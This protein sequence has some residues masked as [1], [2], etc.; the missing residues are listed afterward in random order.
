MIIWRMEL[1]STCSAD[2]S[3]LEL[4]PGANK[5]VECAAFMSDASTG[6]STSAKA[7]LQYRAFARIFLAYGALRRRDAE[8]SKVLAEE[9]KEAMLLIKAIFST[10]V[11]GNSIVDNPRA[12]PGGHRSANRLSIDSTVQTVSTVPRSIDLDMKPGRKARKPLSPKNASEANG[13]TKILTTP[14]KA[15]AKLRPDAHHTPLQGFN[16]SAWTSEVLDEP[17][18]AIATLSNAFRYISGRS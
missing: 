7:G 10:S 18:R 1:I 14:S 8:A 15:K 5:V 11:I 3:K 12:A 9:A 2:P 17:A 13:N 4:E 16:K 6:D